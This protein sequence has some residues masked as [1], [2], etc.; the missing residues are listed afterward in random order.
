MP[1]FVVLSLA[2]AVFILGAA[3]VAGL[4]V[5]KAVRAL[6]AGVTATTRRLRPLAEELQAELAVAEAELAALRRHTEDLRAERERASKA[7]RRIRRRKPS[8]GRFRTH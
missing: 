4:Q 6:I 5:A 8:H 2:L 1:V 3:V 7:R